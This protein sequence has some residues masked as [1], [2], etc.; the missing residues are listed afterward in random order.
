M[1]AVTTAGAALLGWIVGQSFDG[2]ALPLALG[3]LVFGL[4]A[5]ALTLATEH[6]RL[7]AH[8]DAR[9]ASHGA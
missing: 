8:A 7:S 9:D 6:G 2:T 5:L 3:F 1:G 4:A